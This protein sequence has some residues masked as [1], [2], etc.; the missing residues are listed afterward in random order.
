M[1]TLVD[2]VKAVGRYSEIWDG[3]DQK[4]RRVGSGVYMLSLQFGDY[5]RS[6]KIIHLK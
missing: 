2:E 3:K 5:S 6:K 1:R 4:G